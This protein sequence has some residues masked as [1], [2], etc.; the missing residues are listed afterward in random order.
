MKN[1][2][3]NPFAWSVDYIPGKMQKI[4]SL[5]EE[6][7]WNIKK[8]MPDTLKE[9]VGKWLKKFYPRVSSD[10]DITEYLNYMKD[11]VDVMQKA[12]KNNHSLSTNEANF[13][14]ALEDE[15]SSIIA[16]TK[17]GD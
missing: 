2:E 16:L 6:L 1:Y 17:A 11:C 8:P 4:E 5:F 14:D 13:L 7:G 15:L 12:K 3:T 9:A 10:A